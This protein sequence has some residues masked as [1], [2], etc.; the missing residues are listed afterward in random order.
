[1][2]QVDVFEHWVDTPDGKLFA[3]DW[4]PLNAQGVP[5][6]L[7]HDSLGCVALWRDF[8]QQLAAATRQR[9]IAYDRLGFGRSDAHPGRL[10]RGFV[11]AE[12]EQGFAALRRQLG[13]GDFIVFGHSVGGGMAVGCA[14]THGKHCRGLIIES[15]QAFVEDLTLQG[16][17]E[18]DQQFAAPG[19][20]ERLARYHGD[21][22]EWVLRAW[23]DTWLDDAF[24]D[25]NLDALLAQVHCPLLSLHGDQDEFGSPAH[26]RRFTKLAAGPSAM[27]LLP[28][29][30]HVPHRE[31]AEVVLAE[32][33]RFLG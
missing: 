18:A 7:L 1:M 14:V 19:Q 3:Q 17:R 8:P 12:A 32:V 21:K 13:I 29:C 9:V 11:E 10:R 25:W 30:G 31:R 20:L 2:M 4:R 33:Q 24:A 28:G 27:C 22:A 23:V 5:I 15:A 6:I 26:P 16:I